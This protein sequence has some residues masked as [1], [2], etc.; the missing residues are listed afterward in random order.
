MLPVLRSSEI[1]TPQLPMPEAILDDLV[2]AQSR[3]R[4]TL[5]IAIVGLVLLI[6]WA[7][8]SKI[9]QVTRA[10]A[11][12][13]ASARTQ[14][15]QAVDQGVMSQLHVREGDEVIVGQLLVTLE[16]ARAQAAVDDSG[17]KV[18][19]LRITLAR[20]RAEVYGE[21]LRFDPELLLYTEYIENQRALYQRRK[22][23]ID[24]DVASLKT[25]LALANQE[26]EMN[27][28]LLSTGDVS[29]AD[30]LR[31]QRIAADINAQ[32]VN[33]RNKYFQDSQTEMTKAQE[34]LSTQTEQ[35]RD[36]QQI[37]EHTELRSPS[38]GLVKS[39]H[40]TTLGAVVRPGELVMEIVPTGGDLIVEAKISPVDI[41][42][43]E[44]GQ[45][46]SVKLDAYDYSIFGAMSGEVLYISPDTLTETRQGKEEPYYRVQI[47]IGEAEFKD[48]NGRSRIR[49]R[50][51]MT[52]SVDI[53]AMERTVLS[54]L[55]KPITRT[56]SQSMGER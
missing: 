18:A 6:V 31:L 30:I 27:Q 9:D 40:L 53:K 25:A 44:V 2:V 4:W 11:Q 48:A 32:I 33:K 1:S 7:G 13:I 50:P 41:A 28:K 29:K 15:V 5:R 51:G 24:E 8:M 14:V 36:R 16:K 17:G 20:L 35:M 54:Y 45:S 46:A 55:T 39:I 38:D 43:V 42:F 34:E 12:V 49:I 26:L 10:Q 56:L 47:R 21:P 52:A 23:A 3:A 19:A 22:R 37:L